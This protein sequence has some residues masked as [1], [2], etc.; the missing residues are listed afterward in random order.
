MSKKEEVLKIVNSMDESLLGKLYDVISSHT[1]QTEEEKKKEMVNLFLSMFNGCTTK[2]ENNMFVFYKD[3]L[4]M[5]AQDFKNNYFRVSFDRVW[6]IFRTKYRLND[7]QLIDLIDGI[8]D[9][10]LDCKVLTPMV[11]LSILDLTLDEYLD[12]K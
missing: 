7:T 9:K 5:F 8:L 3:E 6:S 4:W 2:I 1:K 10:C 12:C 11:S